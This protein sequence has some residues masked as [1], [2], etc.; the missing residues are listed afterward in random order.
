[1]SSINSTCSSVVSFRG[2]EEVDVSSALDILFAELQDNLNSCHCSVRQLAMS[3]ERADSYMEAATHHFAIEDFVDLLLVLFKELKSVSK[4]VLGTCPKDY[5]DEFKALQE[6]RK[7]TK[8][9]TK[10]TLSQIKE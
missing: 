2:T 8:K 10:D 4:Q 1:M 7:Q 3:E 5:K 9:M 6:K